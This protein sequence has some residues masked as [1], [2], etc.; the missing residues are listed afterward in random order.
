MFAD[1]NSVKTGENVYTCMYKTNV[2][3]TWRILNILQKNTKYK[4]VFTKQSQVITSHIKS[5]ITTRIRGIYTT[6]TAY[7]IKQDRLEINEVKPS[8]QEV[9][10]RNKTNLEKE[11][12]R[13]G[14]N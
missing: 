2:P 6:F 5:M 9:G 11:D 7:L 4:T 12:K 14:R 10:K 1:H 3:N 13:R 8:T